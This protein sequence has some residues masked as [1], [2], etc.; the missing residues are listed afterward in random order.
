MASLAARIMIDTNFLFM[1]SISDSGPSSFF[2][3]I[4]LKTESSLALLALEKSNLAMVERDE[5]SG[6]N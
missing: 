5:R 4:R 3:S 1:D 6:L 2:Q